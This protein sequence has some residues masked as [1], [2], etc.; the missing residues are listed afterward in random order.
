MRVSAIDNGTY[1]IRGEGAASDARMES[2]YYTVST[3]CRINLVFATGA[4]SVEYCF[5]MHTTYM[6]ASEDSTDITD[7]VAQKDYS[8]QID[9][10]LVYAD[11]ALLVVNKPTKLLSVPGRGPDKQDC[12]IT[13]LQQRY[14][15]ALIVHRLD[16]D[17][18]GLLVVARGKVMHRHLSM[19]FQERQ[20]EKC[21]IALV[22]GRVGQ[23]SGTIDLPVAVDWPNRPLHK[24]N[25]EIGKPARTLYRVVDFDPAS[26]TS[27]M[28][29]I[30]ETGRTHQLR[31]HMQA[32]GY[33]ILGDPL[34]APPP[35]QAKTDR[36][37]LHAAMLSFTHPL[38][39][40]TISFTSPADF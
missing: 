6:P 20:V 8:D 17:T 24:V 2:C 37:M 12:L 22:F 19:Q 40:K 36:L 30:P 33:P 18:S 21:Y 1:K 28:E 25:F 16:Y 13:R 10:M 34:Y 31:V 14:P 3:A 32:L 35:V 9:Q 38:S 11:Q 7:L 5:R 23:H 27:R 39:E 26:N 4:L 15:D 29:L